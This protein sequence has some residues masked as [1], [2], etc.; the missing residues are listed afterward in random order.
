MKLVI[1]IRS[2]TR[3]NIP[4]QESY[5]SSSDRNICVYRRSSCHSLSAETAETVTG[6]HKYNIFFVLPLQPTTYLYKVGRCDLTCIN[7]CRK[8]TSQSKISHGIILHKKEKCWL[9]WLWWLLSGALV[10]QFSVQ[11][12]EIEVFKSLYM[13]RR[14]KFQYIWTYNLN[15]IVNV[16]TKSHQQCA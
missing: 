14:F 8:K 7:G 4:F 15:I 13:S 6:C 9:I 10:G 12:N 16:N 2:C 3:W 1:G 5:S 11:P